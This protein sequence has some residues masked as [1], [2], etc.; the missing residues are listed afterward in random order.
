MSALAQRSL[1]NK[2]LGLIGAGNMGEALIKALRVK[3]QGSRVKVFDTNLKRRKYIRQCYKIDI[4]RNNIALVKE[5]DIVI[6]AVKPQD[7]ALVFKEL[8]LKPHPDILRNLFISIA[9]GVTTR[10]IE[11]KLGKVK[12]I[13]VMPNMAI[14]VG[15]AISAIAT[16]RFATKDD[17]QIVKAIFELAGKTVEVKEELMDAVTAMSGSGPAYFFY[18]MNSLIN[19]G[20]S[21]GL[22]A[23]N[24]KQLVIQTALGAVRIL[25][26]SNESFESLIRRVASKGGTTEAALR[27]FKERKLERIIKEAVLACAKRSEELSC[28]YSHNF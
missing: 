24:S 25:Q 14:T 11:D 2:R 23:E 19:S 9:A 4:A 10:Y 20:I 6:L 28:L 8:T 26:E 16:G 3:A 1:K 22:D 18:I 7:M 12:V 15:E 5:S 13:R 27:I 17:L 21:L